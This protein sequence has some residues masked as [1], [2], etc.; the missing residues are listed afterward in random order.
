MATFVGGTKYSAKESKYLFSS[1]S[2]S[3]YVRDVPLWIT[4][5]SVVSCLELR[6]LRAFLSFC[7]LR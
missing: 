7:P 2:L 5:H 4:S 6:P 1:F 3:Y